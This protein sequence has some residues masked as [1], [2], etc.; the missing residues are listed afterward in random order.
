MNNI[1]SKNWTMNRKNLDMN[2]Q[3]D[4]LGLPGLNYFFKAPIHHCWRKKSLRIIQFTFITSKSQTSTREIGYHT[5]KFWLPGDSILTSQST[6]QQYETNNTFAFDN[7]KI[8]CVN[9]PIHQWWVQL[10]SLII[11][12]TFIKL[13]GWTYSRKIGYHNL[14]IWLHG[15]ILPEIHTTQ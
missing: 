6:Q 7:W 8:G 1:C 5:L 11:Q 10:I 9:V 4:L 13:Q 12:F 14:T 2:P 3:L 15:E